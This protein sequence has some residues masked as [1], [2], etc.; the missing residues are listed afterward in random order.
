MFKIAIK[1]EIRNRKKFFVARKKGKILG[2]RKK[3]KDFTKKDAEKLF[4]KNKTLS[5]TKKVTTLTNV[6]EVIDFSE[7]PD[8]PSKQTTRKLQYFFEITDKKNMIKIAARSRQRDIAT[9]KADL[10]R[11]AEENA[12]MRYAQ[13]RGEEYDEDEGRKLFNKLPEKKREVNQGFVYYRKRI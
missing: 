7:K 12:L 9:T 5:E 4:K 1:V 2:V 3:T 13:A 8:K 6:E 10:R 11:E